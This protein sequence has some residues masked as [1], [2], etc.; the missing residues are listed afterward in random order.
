[1]VECG[2]IRCKKRLD[3]LHDFIH[4]V[5]PGEGLVT[6]VAKVGKC[7]ELKVP[8]SWIWKFIAAF[9]LSFILGGYYLFHKVDSTEYEYISKADAYTRMATIDRET[10]S[11]KLE[12]KVF[13]ERLTQQYS[14]LCEK[15]GK[16]NQEMSTMN[17]RLGRIERV[18]MD[19]AKLKDD[20]D[21]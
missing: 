3:D 8:K 14:N 2:D 21:S 12:I 6:E 19:G 9:G 5:K 13:Q 18:H 1:M 20:D 16:I 17:K 7:C 4:G 10:V 11:N 15:L